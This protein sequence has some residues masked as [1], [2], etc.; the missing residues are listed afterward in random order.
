MAQI[1]QA[2]EAS[3]GRVLERPDPTTAPFVLK[4][5]G[6]DGRSLDLVCYAFTANKYRQ[7]G[8]PSNEHR[9]QVKYGSEFHR[10]HNLYL[11]PKGVRTTLMF[12]VHLEL[13]LFVGIDPRMHTPTWFSSSVE[14]KEGDLEEARSKGWHGWQRDRSSVRRKSVMPIEDLR[15]EVVIGFRPEHFL[16]YVDLEN[17]AS[18]L[19]PGERLL[20][21]DGIGA[22]LADGKLVDPRHVLEAQLGLSAREI[23]DVIGARFRLKADVRGSVAEHHLG[24]YLQDVPGVTGVRHIDEDGRPDFEISYKNHAVRIECKN[25]LGRPAKDGPRVDFQKTRASKANPCSRYYQPTQFDVLAAC[26]HPI[27]ERWDFMFSGTST[28][29]PHLR[30]PGRLSERV[31]V[32]GPTWMNNLPRLLDALTL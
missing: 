9:F 27:T 16:R 11:D 7:A 30:C 17:V 18:G 20:L 31:V 4:A 1:E 23:L 6:A 15:T 32:A 24:R 8:R 28:L 19:D 25:V 2:I 12:G 13:G 14:M 3:G 22:R 21:S 10:Y 29:K 26:L 5:T